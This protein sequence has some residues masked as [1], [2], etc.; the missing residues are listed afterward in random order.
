M[1]RV[2]HPRRSQFR[3]TFLCN[4]V[5]VNAACN[6]FA[7]PTVTF[8][9]LLAFVVLSHDRRLIR[10]VAVTAHPTAAWIARH[11][12]LAFPEGGRPRYLVRNRER[13]YGRAFLEQ[14]QALAIEDRRI[15]PRQCWM[16]AYRERLI[17]T[18]RRECT[19]HLIVWCERQLLAC[20]REY[21]EYY[22]AARPHLSL[23]RNAP[24]PRAR[25]PRLAA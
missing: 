21:V 20:L 17:G 2:R 16:N 14:L 9:N 3:T 7:V 25:E 13:I 15:A 1:A 6:F 12:E 24:I 8:R 23:E 5:S 22:N 19:D 11:I 18:L 10:H 4:H